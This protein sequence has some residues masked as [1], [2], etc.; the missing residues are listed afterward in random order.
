MRH[1]P[2]HMGRN[3]VNTVAGLNVDLRFTHTCEFPEDVLLFPR[4]Q[5]ATMRARLNYYRSTRTIVKLAKDRASRMANAPETSLDDTACLIV[6][7]NRL[8]ALRLFP[9]SCVL[10]SLA[11]LFFFAEEGCSAN[12]VIGV[13]EGPFATRTWLEINGVVANDDDALVLN[14]LPVLQTNSESDLHQALG[15]PLPAHALDQRP[16]M[17]WPSDG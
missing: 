9:L 7:Y 13:K 2:G 17:L 3:N 6:A 11:C 15:G 4:F 1:F 14:Y 16:G 8:K 12:L 10:D 5:G